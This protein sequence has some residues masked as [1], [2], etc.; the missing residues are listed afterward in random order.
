MQYFMLYSVFPSAGYVLFWTLMF[1]YNTSHYEAMNL[2]MS[3]FIIW[4]RFKL[5]IQHLCDEFNPL[6]ITYPPTSM[7]DVLKVLK[8][9]NLK[10]VHSYVSSWNCILDD[11]CWHLWFSLI[12]ACFKIFYFLNDAERFMPEL[13]GI[14]LD[15]AESLYLPCFLVQ[16]IEVFWRIDHGLYEVFFT[17]IGE[18][19]YCH[20]IFCVPY[21]WW[22][23]STGFLLP[24]SQSQQA[25]FW[26]DYSL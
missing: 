18:N 20:R 1:V 15:Y 9:F 11:C 8:S 4:F 23:S 6:L 19:W 12:N 5:A 25:V 7:N 17:C 16:V 13:R 10:A 14:S 2:F 26:V 3:V 24:V 21:V 22:V